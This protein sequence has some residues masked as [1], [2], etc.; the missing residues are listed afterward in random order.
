MI[1]FSFLLGA[2]IITAFGG[3]LILLELRMDLELWQI[4][5]GQS[6][7]VLLEDLDVGA[8]KLVARLFH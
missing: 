8:L 7:S 2:I 3:T 1:I 5:L 6:K 4:E